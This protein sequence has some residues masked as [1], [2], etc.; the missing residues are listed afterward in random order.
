MITFPFIF[1]VTISLI[2]GIGIGVYLSNR[3]KKKYENELPDYEALYYESA[4]RLKEMM[5]ESNSQ[6]NMQ[7]GMTE[8]IVWHKTLLEHIIHE[9]DLSEDD[10][11]KLVK[12]TN[13]SLGLPTPTKE[14]MENQVEEVLKAMGMDDQLEEYKKIKKEKTKTKSSKLDIDTILEKIS[15]KGM[16]SLTEAEKEFLNNQ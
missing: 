15:N 6:H 2:F 10:V 9:Y 12:K 13:D 14:E 16:E 4:S 7:G 11:Y 1:G 8:A 3:M 5:T